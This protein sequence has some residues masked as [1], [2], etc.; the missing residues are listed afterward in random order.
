M[1]AVVELLSLKRI[2][3]KLKTAHAGHRITITMP[4]TAD[5]RYNNRALSTNIF[6]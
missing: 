3:Q 5:K 6:S 1:A 2:T 4:F